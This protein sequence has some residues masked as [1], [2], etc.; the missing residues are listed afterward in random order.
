MLKYPQK[1]KNAIKVADSLQDFLKMLILRRKAKVDQKIEKKTKF[2]VPIFLNMDVT[3]MKKRDVVTLSTIIERF[4]QFDATFFV[5]VA[6]MYTFGHFMCTLT[7]SLIPRGKSVYIFVTV[8]SNSPRG[9]KLSVSVHLKCPKVYI[10]A[11]LTKKVA[12]N[13]INR[14][15]MVESVTTSGYV[16]SVTSMF[17]NIGTLNFVFFSTFW[18]TFAF[19]PE[20][21]HF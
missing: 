17:R 2:K 6:K 16:I 21:K 18:A 5:K 19:P 9:I 8:R 10:F 7:D 12:S 11:T 14:S 3:D 1:P 4:M 20:D 15:I 13:C